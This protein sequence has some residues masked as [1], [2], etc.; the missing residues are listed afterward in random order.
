[1]SFFKSLI[2]KGKEV[3]KWEQPSIPVDA[4]DA[5]HRE[6]ICKDDKMADGILDGQEQYESKLG[7]FYRKD[8]YVSTSPP[9]LGGKILLP[10]TIKFYTAPYRPGMDYCKH[11]TRKNVVYTLNRQREAAKIKKLRDEKYAIDLSDYQERLSKPETN[12]EAVEELQF[13]VSIIKDAHEMDDVA[14]AKKYEKV[15]MASKIAGFAG[16]VFGAAAGGIGLAAIASNS[17]SQSVQLANTIS[18]KIGKAS[19]IAEKFGHGP[20]WASITI[21]TKATSAVAGKVAGMI[22]LGAA[23]N[24]TIPGATLTALAVVSTAA[25]A[26]LNIYAKQIEKKKM[27]LQMNSHQLVDSITEIIKNNGTLFYKEDNPMFQTAL[28]IKDDLDEILNTTNNDYVINALDTFQKNDKVSAA[29]M[30]NDMMVNAANVSRNGPF[31]NELQKSKMMEKV[32]NITLQKLRNRRAK[33]KRL[34][35]LTRKN[36][37]V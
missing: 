15:M 36:K 6:Y 31:E 21:G 23:A 20:N 26:G 30:L 5:V 4:K 11:R 16:M 8:D 24:L 28:T 14:L 35:N 32:N 12:K 22:I 17:A 7:R 29:K 1:M 34:H 9:S 18:D 33:L 25:K 3:M 27:A 37:S 13:F 2:Q 19:T 10:K